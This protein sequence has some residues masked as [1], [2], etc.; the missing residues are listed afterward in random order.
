MEDGEDGG[1]P[2]NGGGGGAGY[3]GGSA[4][5]TRGGNGGTSYI[6]PLLCTEIS[7]GYATVAED[8]ERNLTNPWT[9]YGF[10]ELE[11]GR[12]ETKRILVKDSDGYKWFNGTDLL[13]GT[14]NSNAT[15]QWEL[16]PDQTDPDDEDYINYGGTIITNVDGLQNNV[17]FLVSSIEPQENISVSG[18]V[19]GTIVELVK[20]FSMSDV[21]ELKSITAVTNLENVDV[22]FAISK[23]YGKTYQTYNFGSWTDVNISNKNEF[24][25]NGYNLAQFSTIPIADWNSYGAKIIRFA[26]C[27]TQNDSTGSNAILQFISYIADLVGSWRHFT[28]SQVTYEYISDS[29]IKITFLEGGNYKVNYLD[30]LNSGSN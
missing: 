12:D 10:I 9:A 23:D 7:R 8:S 2:Y 30:Q 24:Q 6:N 14:I 3:S 27:I 5:D 25:N 4:S 26:F 16:I 29:Q 28:E 15:D 22:K 17:K 1:A 11:L 21:S 20:D 19:N 18:N 13:D